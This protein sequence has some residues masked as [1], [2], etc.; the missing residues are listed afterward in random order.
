MI[1]CLIIPSYNC[2]VLFVLYQYLQTRYTFHDMLCVYIFFEEYDNNI[3][4]YMYVY[5]YI[6]VPSQLIYNLYRPL[7]IK[8]SFY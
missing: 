2:S 7:Y 6:H 4:A 5:I 8:I 1:K 3:Y